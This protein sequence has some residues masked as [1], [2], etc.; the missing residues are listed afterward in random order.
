MDRDQF[1]ELVGRSRRD[2][3]ADQPDGNMERQ[4]A[5]LS[6]LLAGLAPSEI[7]SFHNHLHGSMLEAYA[8]DLWGAATLLSDGYCSDD[9]FTDFCAW[10]ISMG[11]ATY[12]AA[13]EN[14]DSL[15][16]TVSDRTVEVFSF[17]ELPSVAAAV[18]EEKT[19][20]QMPEEG[21]EYPPHPRGERRWQTEQ[22]LESLYPGIRAALEALKR[23]RSQ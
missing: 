17:E 8:W 10:L 2:L 3:R 21:L 18:Y 1:W 7:L 4:A 19:G 9:G 16:A 13:L 20:Q 14:P 23:E 6:R 5:E 22:E 15:A 11:R 12:E